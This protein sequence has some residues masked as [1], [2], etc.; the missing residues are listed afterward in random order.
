[1][2][3]FILAMLLMAGGLV[4]AGVGGFTK[5]GATIGG[6]AAAVVVGLLVLIFSMINSVPVHSVGVVTAFGKINGDIRPGIHMLAPWDN[7]TVMDETIQ[8]TQF[9][10][11][12]SQH[13]NCMQVRLGGQ[14]LACLNITIKWQ[15]MDSG[16]PT[17]FNDYDNKGTNVMDSVK[18]NLVVTDLKQV[19]NSVFGDYNPIA[20]ATQAATTGNKSQFSTFGPTIQQQM[21]QDMS[22]QVRVLAVILSNPYYNG[23]TEAR[24]ASIQNQIADTA[25]AQQEI[26]TNQALAQANAALA[27]SLTP[28]LV[29]QNCVTGTL[30][31]VKNG[32]H[33]DDGWSCGAASPFAITGSGAAR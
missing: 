15:V 18:N 1:M 32:G 2:F 26:K 23:T 33:M 22:G 20:D 29:F 30:D 17:L 21:Q 3:L 28:T 27:R 31:V 13:G 14:Q 9:Y 25:I 4:A 11:Q 10:G 24:L 16:A 5:R 12:P 6:G 7:V 19:A 8:T